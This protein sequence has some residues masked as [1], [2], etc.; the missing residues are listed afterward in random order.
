[1]QLCF[2]LSELVCACVRFGVHAPPYLYRVYLPNKDC[3]DI[4]GCKEAQ[5]NSYDKINPLIEDLRECPEIR[6]N[7]VLADMKV[8]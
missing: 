3:K 6:L 2:F 5:F 4:P 8:C 7:F 1:M